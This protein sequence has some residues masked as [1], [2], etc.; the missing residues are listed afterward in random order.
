M[1]KNIAILAVVI[2]AISLAACKSDYKCTCTV[3]NISADTVF[4]NVTKKEAKAKCQDIENQGKAIFPDY[5]C[6][7]SKAK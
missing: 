1:W 6:E 5:K 3:G 7:V 4:T 2:G